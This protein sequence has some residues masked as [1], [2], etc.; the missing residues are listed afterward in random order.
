[1][2]VSASA[3]T[4]NSR[5]AAGDAVSVQTGGG[6]VIVIDVVTEPIL[7]QLLP[8]RNSQDVVPAAHADD[9]GALF[10]EAGLKSL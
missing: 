9:H 5:I 8:A 10:R 6:W 1:M 7:P 4:L 2:Q 3:L